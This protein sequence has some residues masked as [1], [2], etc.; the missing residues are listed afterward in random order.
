MDY[1]TQPNQDFVGF[2]YGKWHCIRDGHVYRT[3]DGSRFNTNL[4]PTLTDKTSDAPGAD[5]QY[6]FDSFYKN[7]QFSVSFAFDDLSEEKFFELQKVFNGKEIKDL[8]FDELPYKA[9]SAKVTG[10]PQL[11][12]LCFDKDENTRVYKGEGTVQFTCYF[13][14]AHTPN[15][16][17]HLSGG[18][19]IAI[20]AD[21]RLFSSYEKNI[22]T[23]KEQWLAAS[24]MLKNE[25]V[26][27]HNRGQLPAPFIVDGASGTVSVA[28]N[29]INIPNDSN[30]TWD[31]K[32]GLVYK[33]DN[34]KKTAVYYTGNSC[35]TIPVG[36]PAQANIGTLTF[37][38]LYY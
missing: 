35:A 18:K 15:W 33:T 16:V 5:G 3:S 23:T 7:R 10:T 31:S 11:K 13:P 6:Y 30:C 2:S 36:E 32:T 24:G 22:Y 17:W 37:Q 8:I 1:A 19:V 28:G 25:T 14:F 29:S 9:Y 26:V 27:T 4:I 34:G 12:A 38:Y 20:G 21:G